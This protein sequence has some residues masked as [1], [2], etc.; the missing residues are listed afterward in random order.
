MNCEQVREMLSAYLDDTLALGEAAQS[1]S[2]LKRAVTAHLE[3]CDQCR[4]VL[5]DYRRF[6]DLL[7][8]MPR[9][10]PDPALRE[11]IFSSPEYFELTGTYDFGASP[12]RRSVDAETIPY[13]SVRNP[14]RRGDR[15]SHPHLVALPGGRDPHSNAPT[16]PRLSST[17]ETRL[18][19]VV[20]LPPQEDRS[21]PDRN[22]R[23]T[24]GNRVALRV[25]QIV[26][27]AVVLLTLGVGSY[28][29]YNLLARPSAVSHTQG[30]IPPAGLPPRTALTEGMHFVYLSNGALESSS[31][32]GNTQPQQLTPKNVTVAA[33]W[34]V[35]SP[36]PGRY[37]GDMLAYIDLQ[38][39]RVHIIRSDSL[40]DSVIQQPLFPANVSPESQWDTA[41]G[42]AILQSLAW[43]DDGSMLA[44]VA[45]PNGT[46]Q[47]SLYIYSI[48]T[49]TIQKVAVPMAGSITHPVWSP[50]NA[51]V[52]F[53][54]TSASSES[55]LDYN[56]QN[57]GLLVIGK[58]VASAA[59]PN[60]SVLS[61]NWSPAVNAPAIT[62]SVG[63]IGHVH[64]LW[65]Q[66]VGTDWTPNPTEIASGDY[67]QAS[68][69][70]NG[71]GGI[72]S[73][74]L[75]SSV[76]GQAGNIF[77]LD[78]APGAALVALTSGKQ[79]N[80]AQWSPDGTKI[81]YLDALSAGVGTLHIVDAASANDTLIARNVAEEPIP[82]WSANGE[83]FVYS[84]GTHIFVV[85]MANANDTNI[86]PLSLRGHVS[87]LAWFANS[88]QQL[89]VALSDGQPG[90]YFVDT[91]NYHIQQINPQ[92]AVSGPIVW[93][94]VP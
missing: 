84:T 88:A 16:M 92:D 38:H 81:A 1:A 28:I 11:R 94:E 23:G 18:R 54:L 29:S 6:D 77:R 26:I 62:W 64:S 69:S 36:L 35:S 44:F 21:I 25:M 71:H 47:T 72:G 41:T 85:N 34:R 70:R 57:D 15:S 32:T 43:S 22:K 53:E 83:Q 80:V 9:V 90:V 42:S 27:A 48:Q 55:I 39:A 93:T 87:S 37:A 33:G 20:P 17:R 89:V 12:L 5:W 82:A 10:N 56:T 3:D 4:A 86:T 74:M 7:R 58:H 19:Q 24:G 8:Q 66:H 31:I 63:E 49:G 46:G 14:R 73:W 61:L 91:H 68:Y 40:N 75:I 60:D 59:Y 78:I 51:R 13:R 79:V 45:D 52:A 30:I 65:L 2:Q 50:D 67:A 76:D